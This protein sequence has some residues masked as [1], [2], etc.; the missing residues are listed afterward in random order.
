M[1]RQPIPPAPHLTSRGICSDCRVPAVLA[2]NGDLKVC[3]RCHAL[4]WHR[5]YMGEQR[6]LKQEAAKTAAEA[7]AIRRAEKETQ[8]RLERESSKAPAENHADE[9]M[10][11]KEAPDRVMSPPAPPTDDDDTTF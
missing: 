5:D 9:C 4:L 6:R 3:P 7:A 10:E 1:F 11:K 2:G 8:R